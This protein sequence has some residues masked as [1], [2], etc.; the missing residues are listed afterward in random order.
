M[1][2]QA[3]VPITGYDNMLRA[4]NEPVPSM[5]GSSKLTA[6]RGNL[7]Q[8]LKQSLGTFRNYG[9]LWTRLSGTQ[10]PTPLPMEQSSVSTEI[11][12]KLQNTCGQPPQQQLQQLQQLWVLV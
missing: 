8:N 12:I 10:A 5:R 1:P 11:H 3:I 2:N 6:S 7:D 4:Y 9:N